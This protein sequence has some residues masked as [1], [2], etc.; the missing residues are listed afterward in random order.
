MIEDY[1]EAIYNLLQSGLKNSL[2]GL[3]VMLRRRTS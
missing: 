2:T 1:G 3:E